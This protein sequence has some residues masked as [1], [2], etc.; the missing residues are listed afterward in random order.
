MR[1]LCRLPLHVS[2]DSK[3]D[4]H[5]SQSDKKKR[6]FAEG[7]LNASRGRQDAG[8]RWNTTASIV[9]DNITD[10]KT[11]ITRPGSD[12]RAMEPPAIIKEPSDQSGAGAQGAGVGVKK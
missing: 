7:L 2:R 3:L 11:R 10:R 9:F 1:G 12:T 8:N 5:I 6:I 4:H